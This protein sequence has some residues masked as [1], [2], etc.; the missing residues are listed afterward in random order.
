[1]ENEGRSLSRTAT[2][3]ADSRPQRGGATSA[4]PMFEIS[5]AI[6]AVPYAASGP[7]RPSSARGLN[8]KPE[9]GGWRRHRLGKACGVMK[10]GRVPNVQARAVGAS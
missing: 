6:G 5:A 9:L 7:Q 3:S 4:M 1:M 10:F 2:A 8:V